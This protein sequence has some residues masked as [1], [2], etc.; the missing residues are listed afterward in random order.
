MNRLSVILTIGCISVACLAAPVPEATSLHPAKYTLRL[1]LATGEGPVFESAKGLSEFSRKQNQSNPN[2]W[3]V[4]RGNTIPP[5][6]SSLV[7]LLD[8]ADAIYTEL[9]SVPVDIGKEFTSENG[10]LKGT[11]WKKTDFTA[12][13]SDQ[14]NAILSAE[15]NYD[16]IPVNLREHRM[17][18]GEWSCL[19]LGRTNNVGYLLIRLYEPQR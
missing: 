15:L 3:T 12:P 17:R 9:E 11:I 10:L 16:A 1:V 18:I 6:S 5:E 19:A 8:Q 4:F 7:S 13:G 2:G 14:E